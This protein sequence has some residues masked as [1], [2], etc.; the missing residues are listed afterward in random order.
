MLPPLAWLMVAGCAV[1]IDRTHSMHVGCCKSFDG[2]LG[3]PGEGPPGACPTCLPEVW[4]TDEWGRQLAAWEPAQPFEVDTPYGRQ[5]LSALARARVP[6]WPAGGQWHMRSEADRLVHLRWI[7]VVLGQPDVQLE[8]AFHRAAR[9]RVEN[10]RQ[11]HGLTCQAP[12]SGSPSSRLPARQAPRTETAPPPP[13]QPPARLADAPSHGL[14][15]PFTVSRVFRNDQ[16]A[17]YSG[18]SFVPIG[19]N[20][21]A[22]ASWFLC[23][24]IA[25]AGGLSELYPP[26][27]VPRPDLPAVWDTLPNWSGTAVGSLT[28]VQLVQ[29]AAV[30]LGQWHVS[31]GGV[32]SA[33]SIRQALLDR[34]DMQNHWPAALQD[35]VVALMVALP[36]VPTSG[37][38][39]GLS[40]SDA[41]SE[42]VLALLALAHRPPPALWKPSH[43]VVQRR[44]QQCSCTR[45][46]IARRQS[47]PGHT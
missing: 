21:Q 40:L 13:T 32:G 47:E 20:S 44:Q 34:M 24:L 36:G 30:A 26:A 3:F 38:V 7:R 18:S 28:W 37:N 46:D 19:Q 9:R 41:I 10:Y 1:G 14:A 25:D 29:F 33:A 2:T 27:V 23:P 39:V 17:C 15:V 42:A 6:R 5:V 11:R 12:A 45:S 16:W 31:I 35:T 43:F 22:T 8:H 4:T